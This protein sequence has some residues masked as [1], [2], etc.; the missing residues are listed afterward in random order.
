[1]QPIVGMMFPTLRYI[2][3]A[4]APGPDPSSGRAP[5]PPHPREVLMLLFT[6]KRL[7]SGIVLL[8]VV[9]VATFFLAH[10]AIKDPTAALLG[11]TASPAQQPRWR[12]RSASTVRCSCSSGTGSRTW[13]PATSDPPGATSSPWC[14]ARHQGPGDPLRGHLRDAHHRGAR[15]RLRHDHGP[16]PRN[17]VRPDPQGR[18]RRPVR[19]ARLL[20]EPRARDVVRGAAEVVPRGRL[21]AAVAV[22][23]RLDPLAHAARDLAR[24]RRRGRRLGATAQRRDRAEPSGLGAHAPQP[25][26]VPPG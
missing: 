23:R 22:L 13:S 11:T 4:D 10:L 2:T 20:G 21:R 3:R 19:P 18:V 12:R 5:V 8:V 26:P 16:A 17:L 15:H 7:L 25:R 24:A 6:A 9:S 14:A 1:V